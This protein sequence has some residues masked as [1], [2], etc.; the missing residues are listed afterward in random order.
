M[1]VCFVSADENEIRQL[2]LQLDLPHLSADEYAMGAGDPFA[3]IIWGRPRPRREREGGG[4][5]PGSFRA[6]FELN[7]LEAAK[8]AANPEEAARRLR[9]SGLSCGF[10]PGGKLPNPASR[11]FRVYLFHLEAVAVYRSRVNAYVAFER[12][13]PSRL[14]A[15]QP[16]SAAMLPR[17]PEWEEVPAAEPKEEWVRRAEQTACRAL[18]S[19]GLDFGMAE[20]VFDFKGKPTVAAVEPFPVLNERLS[21][22]YASAISR[23]CGRLREERR[24]ESSAIL[25]ADPEFLLENDKGRIVPASHYLPRRG[26]AGCDVLVVRSKVMFPLAELRP[27]PSADPR[28]LLIHLRKAMGLAA[29]RIP[30]EDG[31]RWLAGGMPAKGFPLGGHIHLSGL[32]LNS[33]LLR[34]FDNYLALPLVVIEDERSKNRRPKYGFLGDFR[35]QP[36]G[37]F[38]YRT[39]PSWLVSPRVAKG[40]LALASLLADSYWLLRQRPLD[41]PFYLQAYYEGNKEALASPVRRILPEIRSLPGYGHLETLIE[42]LFQMIERGETWDESR[43]FR[44]GW[45]LPPFAASMR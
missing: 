17:E 37:G 42:P 33:F 2:R 45:K 31:I 18:Y 34:V 28:G 8:A 26:K 14:G 43:D 24:R 29:S 1:D 41:N 44:P 12:L 32:W 27:E 11:K 15:G 6:V 30:A 10:G 4:T 13:L 19:L 20:V 22:A 3:A 7:G 38:E 40:A 39:L 36:H 21:L 16:A 5:E 35:T 25:G 9:L 23:F